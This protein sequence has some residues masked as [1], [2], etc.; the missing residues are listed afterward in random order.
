MKLELK[1]N[2]QGRQLCPNCFCLPSGKC[3][4]L[5][6]FAPLPSKMESTLKGKNLLPREA[7]SFLLEQTPFQKGLGTQES[8]TEVTKIVSCEHGRKSVR[9]IQFPLGSKYLGYL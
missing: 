8:K 3:S 1:F 9:F 2:F 4:T 7:N 5:T 6:E